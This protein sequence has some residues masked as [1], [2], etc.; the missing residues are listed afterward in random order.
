MIVRYEMQPAVRR[1]KGERDPRGER[2]I[3]DWPGADEGEN[4]GLW[5][6]QNVM[7]FAGMA[8]RFNASADLL[9]AVRTGV[10]TELRTLLSEILRKPIPN[11]MAESLAR[12][13][14]PTAKR[15]EVR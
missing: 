11:G 7:A 10:A 5:N 14:Q 13:D 4:A 15:S 3:T 8:P 6:R 1:P 12:L 2:E 9:M